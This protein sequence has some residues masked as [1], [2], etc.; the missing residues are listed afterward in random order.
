MVTQTAS[1]SIF[2]NYSSN[3]RL[4]ATQIFVSPDNR[5]CQKVLSGYIRISGY[6]NPT[7]RFDHER[8]HGEGFFPVQRTKVRGGQR[9][10]QKLLSG[11]IGTWCLLRKE[12]PP[13]EAGGGLETPEQE[14]RIG[15]NA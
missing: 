1:A 11:G 10:P 12:V 3:I 2:A 9:H 8:D 15:I 14:D 7:E 13:G 5:Q 6:D 4:F